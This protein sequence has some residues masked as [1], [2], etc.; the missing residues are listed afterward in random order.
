MTSP[1]TR[2]RRPRFDWDAALIVLLFV[3]Q[4]AAL[5]VAGAPALAPAEA[6]ATLALAHVHT[7]P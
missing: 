1:L 5:V 6:G 4:A 3:A 7:T 2:F